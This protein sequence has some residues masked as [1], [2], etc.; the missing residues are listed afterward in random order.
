MKKAA[1][2]FGSILMAGVMTLS[3]VTVT[4]KVS[5]ADGG[6]GAGNLS[7]TDENGIIYSCFSNPEDEAY[8][9]AY[10]YGVTDEAA[11]TLVDANICSNVKDEKGNEYVVDQVGGTIMDG[12]SKCKN[13]K[14][15]NIPDS[16]VRVED[17]A[18]H[19][20]ASIE[21]VY[22]ADSVEYIGTQAFC[23]CTALETIHLPVNPAFTEIYEL[24]FDGCSSLKSIIIPK[25]VNYIAG[26]DGSNS[27]FDPNYEVNIHGYIGTV[28]ETYAD[29]M[30]L[31]IFWPIDGE[32]NSY[33][34]IQ[35][36]E[37]FEDCFY[38][39]TVPDSFDGEMVL[40]SRKCYLATDGKEGVIAT[41]LVCHDPDYANEFPPECSEL[42][43][44]SAGQY[45]VMLYPSDGISDELRTSNPEAAAEFDEIITRVPSIYASFKE[46]VK[47]PKKPVIKSVKNVKGKKA[48][49][50]LKAKVNGAKGYEYQI[51]LKKN[52]NK[53]VK[54]VRTKKTS[55]TFKKLK[56]GKKYYV[57]V[58]DYKVVT[59]GEVVSA[60]SK[61]KTVK[62]KK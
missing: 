39:D 2:K 40:F 29:N 36:P 46:L 57:R 16:V 20:C 19:S 59:D 4:G 10:V 53:I 38:A 17:G 48:K 28:A 1:R 25:N 30:D 21:T 47:A 52:F 44:Q 51:S 18:F 8:G 3:L 49:V 60:W 61:T 5:N 37:G 43:K 31:K 54:S 24:T 7:V 42:I 62:I 58:R 41:V 55:Y 22:I 13:L 33:F 35:Y 6:Y 15:V 9:T 26:L 11:D 12:F 45:Y 34:Q 27:A 14:S 50:T 56:K 23:D 32:R